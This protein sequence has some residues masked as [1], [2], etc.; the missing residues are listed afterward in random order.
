MTIREIV[1]K[2]KWIFD[3]AEVR[4]YPNGLLSVMNFVSCIQG[5]I[6]TENNFFIFHSTDTMVEQQL[7]CCFFND[8]SVYLGKRLTIIP[9]PNIDKLDIREDKSRLHFII[10]LDEKCERPI[11]LIYGQ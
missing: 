4:F 10:A 3:N 11:G 2:E 7:R 6:V 9:E 5:Y 1:F 8:Q